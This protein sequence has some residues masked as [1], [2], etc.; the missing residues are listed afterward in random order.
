MKIIKKFL[1]SVLAIALCFNVFFVQTTYAAE[2][3]PNAFSL[4]N[5]SETIEIE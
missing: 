4:A 3:M 5:T 1:V 2:S